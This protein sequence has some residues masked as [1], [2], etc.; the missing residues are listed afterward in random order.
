MAKR[1]FGGVK[2]KRPAPS[3][4]GA[5]PAPK[6]RAEPTNGLYQGHLISPAP[7][8]AFAC[9]MR[10]PTR[11]TLVNM[12]RRDP[13]HQ[14]N[15]RPLDV[16]ERLTRMQQ[17]QRCQRPAPNSMPGKSTLPQRKQLQQRRKRQAR[18]PVAKSPQRPAP[19][20]EPVLPRRVRLTSL[21]REPFSLL[22]EILAGTTKEPEPEKNYSTEIA[23]ITESR[24]VHRPS[25]TPAFPGFKIHRLWKLRPGLYSLLEWDKPSREL[26]LRDR[27]NIFATPLPA[28]VKGPPDGTAKC[29]LEIGRPGD[30]R[31]R[32]SVKWVTV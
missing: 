12:P 13:S 26:L 24:D 27:N 10:K 6:K 32:V 19:T 5:S 28:G 9:V 2:T 7:T 11:P 30:G 23:V 18:P 31:H 25:R 14:L 8:T 4:T 1:T 17:E 21:S 29:Y 22:R 3:A 20:P 15:S 16:F